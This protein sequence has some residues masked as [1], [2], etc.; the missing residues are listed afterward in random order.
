MQIFVVVL[1]FLARTLAPV[2]VRP[3]SSVAFSS[4]TAWDS[5]EPSK[6]VRHILKTADIFCFD[7]DSTIIRSETIDDLAEFLGVG[8][9]VRKLTAGAMGGSMNF[10]EALKQRLDLMRPSLAD[11]ARFQEEHR[12][13]FSDGVSAKKTLTVLLED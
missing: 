8:A 10:T 11:I 2:S 13:I 9:E 7:V 6:E 12:P 4:F 5:I 1:N 3:L